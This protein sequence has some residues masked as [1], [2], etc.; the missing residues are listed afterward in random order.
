MFPDLPFLDRLDAAG[1]AGFKGVEWMF[2]Y[3]TPAEVVRGKLEALGLQAVLINA[4][5]G[6]WAGGDRGLAG[7]PG[8]VEEA[9][10]SVATA[11]DYAMAIGCPRIHVMAGL[12]DE[13]V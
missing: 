2:S 5:P 12:R 9:R 13:S 8:R 4:P 6:D 11:I 7:L 1:A 10:A 3:D